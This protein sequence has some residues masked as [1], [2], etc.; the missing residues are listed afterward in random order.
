MPDV[1]VSRRLRL[2]VIGCGLFALL[3]VHVSLRYLIAASFGYVT[4]RAL[5]PTIPF[6]VLGIYMVLLLGLAILLAVWRGGPGV[7]LGT[8]L[9]LLVIEPVTSMFIWG[10][11]CEV[12][13]RAGASLLPEITVDGAKVILYA[14]N[15]SCSASLNVVVI[16]GGVCLAGIGLG[17]GKLPDIALTRWMTFIETYRSSVASE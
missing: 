2:A 10:D 14:W 1:P 5:A 4:Y 8:G 12:G 6:I 11:G 17:T 3:V 7:V 16:V 13:G 9:I 15:G